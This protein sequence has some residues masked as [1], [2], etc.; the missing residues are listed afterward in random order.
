MIII[1]INCQ[2]GNPLAPSS[3]LLMKSIPL[4]K[5]IV[6]PEHVFPKIFNFKGSS[7]TVRELQD[8]LELLVKLREPKCYFVKEQPFHIS[9]H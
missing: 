8:M 3:Q 7:T 4:L 9:W 6:P 2:P 5:L 1:I